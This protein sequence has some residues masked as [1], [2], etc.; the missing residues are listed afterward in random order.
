MVPHLIPM[1]WW[2]DQTSCNTSIP[3]HIWIVEV[4]ILAI[5]GDVTILSTH[6]AHKVTYGA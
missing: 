1:E 2:C 3:L 6:V 4:Q 5:R